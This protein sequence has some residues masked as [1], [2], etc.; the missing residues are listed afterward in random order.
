MTKNTLSSR[1]RVALALAHQEPDRVPVDLLGSATLIVDDTYFALLDH[2]GLDPAVE[3]WRKGFTANYYDERLLA[4]F[5]IDFRRIFMPRR[6]EGEMTYVSEDTYTCPWGITWQHAGPFIN[7][8][9]APLEDLTIDEILAYDWPKPREVWDATGLKERAKHLVESTSYALVARNPV[10]F[11]LLDRGSHL[12]G[13]E[14]FMKDLVARPELAR[15]IIENVL[16]VHLGMYDMFLS[17]VGP[18]VQIVET[19]DDLGGQENLLISPD[20]YRKYFKPAQTKINQLIKSR[21]PGAK[22]FFHSDGAI[23]KIIPD[24]IEAGVDIL[25]PVQPSAAGMASET[26]KEDYGDQLVF[27]GGVDQKPQEGRAE[28]RKRIDALASGGGFILS[29]C[30]NIL[31]AP[32]ANIVAMLE[33]AKTYGRY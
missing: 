23:R 25:N 32:P 18:Y 30:N 19:A 4:I 29:T 31:G 33:E 1:E 20:F 15:V 26:L 5:D 27:H 8:I 12:R 7:P 21:A 2:L 11:G 24:L 28:V 17:Q 9:R 13:M 14:Q 16:E 22:V 10:T 6:P 3:P